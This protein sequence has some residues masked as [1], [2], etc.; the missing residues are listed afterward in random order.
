MSINLQS[1]GKV[2]PDLSQKVRVCATHSK[3]ELITCQYCTAFACDCHSMQCRDCSGLFCV[4]IGTLS[5]KLEIHF[6]SSDTQRK[7]EE[8]SFYKLNVKFFLKILRG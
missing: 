7:F 8:Y 1:I 4:G 6:E 3:G 5:L 2:C